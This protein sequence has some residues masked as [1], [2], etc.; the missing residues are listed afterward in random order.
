MMMIIILLECIGNQTQFLGVQPHLIL[1]YPFFSM[2]WSMQERK[3]MLGVLVWL[4][5]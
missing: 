1:V 4:L 2:V 5:S 3:R